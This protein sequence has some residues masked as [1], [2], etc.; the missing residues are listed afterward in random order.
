M[1]INNL[2]TYQKPL[3]SMAEMC[4][5]R[6]IDG[7]PCCE[8]SP[9]RG[10]TVTRN[11]VDLDGKEITIREMM[12]ITELTE[13]TLLGLWK[14]HN[15]NCEKI[16]NGHGR[17]RESG[18]KK[19]TKYRN[20][21]GDREAKHDIAKSLGISREKVKSAFEL[22]DFDFKKAFEILDKAK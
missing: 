11:W 20:R 2:N 15:G 6:L 7:P 3:I 4:L 10:K 16:I 1:N 19:Y 14:T 13:S 5:Q 17:L 9:M 21:N 8:I 18:R 12:Q 22:V